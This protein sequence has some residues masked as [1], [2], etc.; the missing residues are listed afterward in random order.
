MRGLMRLGI[1]QHMKESAVAAY[2]EGK[3]SLEK[4]AEK[5]DI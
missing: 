1:K 5:A 2:A 4:A 3:I